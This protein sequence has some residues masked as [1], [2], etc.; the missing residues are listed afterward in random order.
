M[1]VSVRS[2]A[3]APRGLKQEDSRLCLL[4]ACTSAQF[5]NL[6][7]LVMALKLPE[8]TQEAGHSSGMSVKVPL[9]VWTENPQQHLEPGWKASAGRS[10][11]LWKIQPA[12]FNFRTS[13]CFIQTAIHP[14]AH[15]FF[16][17][18]GPVHF[19]PHYPLPFTCWKERGRKLARGEEESWIN[20]AV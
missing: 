12:G 1:P 5:V 11:S 10:G 8:E 17:F 9:C 2:E 15:L 20:F 4:A 13:A 19:W 3:Q 7:A 6:P 16:F 18:F 14:S